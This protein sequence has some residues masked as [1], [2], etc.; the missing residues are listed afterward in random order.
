MDSDVSHDP[1]PKCEIVGARLR[2]I[3]RHVSWAYLTVALATL[4]TA[5]SVRTGAIQ[6]P[7]GNY[8]YAVGGGGLGNPATGP[9]STAL[10]TDRTVAQGW[11]TFTLVQL[12]SEQFALQT[13]SG[14][15]V[16]FVNGGGMGGPNDSTSPVHTDATSI[17][18]DSTFIIT[19]LPDNVHATIQTCDGHYLTAN[20]SGGFGGPNNVPIHTDATKAQAWEAFTFVASTCPTLPQPTTFTSINIQVATAGDDARQDDEIVAT[21]PGQ[22]AAF[23]LKASNN[24]TDNFGPNGTQVCAKNS[25]APY[26]GNWSV[27]SAQ[28][29][30]LS[31]SVALSPGQTSFG[32]MSITLIQHPS[33]FEGWDNWNIQ[34]ARVTA[35][36]TNGNTATLLNL[37][38]LISGPSIYDQCISRLQNG[39]AVDTVTFQLTQGGVGT[40]ISGPNGC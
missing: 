25:N 28:T 13:A 36:D 21:M 30:S 16:T 35:T 37:G 18:A 29:F 38:T 1:L 32:T 20:N 14:N 39:P 22:N 33:G 27:A 23:C 11:E 8:L 10:N 17:D 2:R 6:V 7:S 26:W 31:P 3:F 9:G 19:M 5:Q 4:A 15:F 40:I 12:N 34:G 24:G